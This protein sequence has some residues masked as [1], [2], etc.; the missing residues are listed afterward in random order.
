[1]RYFN[2]GWPGSTHDDRAWRKIEMFKNKDE[3]F[4]LMEHLLGDSS[5]TNKNVLCSACEKHPAV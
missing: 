5:F 2:A 4:A 3:H 1:M